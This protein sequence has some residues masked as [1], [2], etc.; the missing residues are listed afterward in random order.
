MIITEILAR[1][2]RMYGDEVAL[3]ERDPANNR[4]V[5]ITWKE[6]DDMAN[7]VANALIEKGIKK[8]DKVIHL[9]MNCIEWLPAYFGILR[10]GA[11]AV[12]LNFRFMAEDIRYCAEIAEARAII[13]GEEF[14]DRVNTIKGDL[15]T[16][17]DYVFAGPVDMMP[18]YSESLEAFLKTGSASWTRPPFILRPEPRANQ[19]LFF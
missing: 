2:A 6:F 9:M 16:I 13:F 8:E 7:R 5:T 1:N 11:W 4:R 17:K 18:D 14:V 10:T 3:I 15:V 12:P 19:S